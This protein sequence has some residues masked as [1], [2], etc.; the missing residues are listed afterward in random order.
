VYAL[1]L[2]KAT[3]STTAVWFDLGPEMLRGDPSV[4]SY[5]PS[6]TE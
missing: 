6:V 2:N 4:D 3:T 1:G 5:Y